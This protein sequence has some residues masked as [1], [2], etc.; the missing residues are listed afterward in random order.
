MPRERRVCSVGGCRKTHHSL[1]LCGI[2]RMY[3]WFYGNHD[4]K[5]PRSCSFCGSADHVRLQCADTPSPAPK[6][7]KPCKVGGCEKPRETFWSSE[8]GH[9]RSKTMCSMHLNRVK[10]YGTTAY[11]T[12]RTNSY[13]ESCGVAGCENLVG[14]GCGGGKGMC[15]K[16]Y[17]RFRKYG[18]PDAPEM[19]VHCSWCGTV[20]HNRSSCPERS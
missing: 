10:K 7:L 19:S 2:H 8:R 1:G 9:R 12:T 16:H 3:L 13:A 6:P 4:L 20:G 11:R 15:G 18:T 17:G 14:R 5:G